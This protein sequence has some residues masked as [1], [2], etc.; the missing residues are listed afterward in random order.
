M[1][2]FPGAMQMAAYVVRLI[3]THDLVGIFFARDHDGLCVVVDECTETD[4]C[5]CAK[6]PHGSIFWPV[7]AVPVP[8][9]YSDVD[10][11]P[12]GGSIPWA[13]AEL[14]ESWAEFLMDPETLWTPLGTY[15]PE[16]VM[17]PEPP[18]PAAEI[19]PW[20]PKAR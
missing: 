1:I 7:P 18:R 13:H 8:Y 5:E 12:E 4:C 3:K 19:L 10:E 6:L 2:L 17:P 16:L 15:K 14:S 11:E 20:R 9:T